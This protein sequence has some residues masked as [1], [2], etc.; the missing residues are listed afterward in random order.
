MLSWVEHEKSFITSGPGN[1]P[2][3]LYICDYSRMR[4]TATGCHSTHHRVIV[5]RF[6]I[7]DN[8]LRWTGQEG[9][10][11]AVCSALDSV[12]MELVQ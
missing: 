10:D 4:S 5:W 2:T 7:Q 11:P 3:G 6:T 12:M 9:F 1:F 8:F